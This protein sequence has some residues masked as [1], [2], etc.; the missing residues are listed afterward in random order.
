MA[1]VL[2]FGDSLTWGFDPATGGRFPADVR[3][4]GVLR[5]ELG[6]DLLV[7]EEGLPGRQTVWG[8]DFMPGR[9]GRDYLPPCLDS[10]APVDVVVLML[11]TNDLQTALHRSVEEVARGCG[12]LVD[13][14]RFGASGPG[15][16]P[17]RVLLVAPPR[18]GA[19]QGIM[20][21]AF[22][23]A[24]DRSQHLA[25]WLAQVA[26]ATGSAFLDASEVVGPSTGPGGDGV[27]LDADGQR[28]LGRAV[29]AAVRPLLVPAD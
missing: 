6:P 4:P 19:V 1:T 18:I 12:S 14:V 24:E 5:A 3:W 21:I 15:G 2:C 7:V 28:A 27:H 22:A 23:G 8:S 9:N 10:H 11:G 17:P 25:S 29:A 20:R 13:I 16:R 26:E